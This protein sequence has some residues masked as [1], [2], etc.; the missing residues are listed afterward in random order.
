MNNQEIIDVFERQ[1]KYFSEGG[2]LDVSERKRRLT[3]LR[4]AVEKYSDLIA[5]ALKSD[6]GKSPSESYMCETGLSL[7]EI[8]YQ[9]KHIKKF[10]KRQKV[11]TPMAQWI[12]TSFRY[13]SPYGTVLVMS[14]W[15]YPIL[16]SLDPL[17]EAIAAGNT[18]ILKPSAYSPASSAVLK[19]IIS[20]VLPEEVAAVIEGGREQNKILLDLDFDYIFFTGSKTVGRQVYEKAASRLTPVTLE[21]GGKSPCIV[22]KTANIS[23]AARRIVFGKYL[24]CGQ[25][26]VAPDYVLC[27]GSVKEAFIEEVKK[28]IVT[29]YGKDP[30][31][32]ADYGRIVSRKHFERVAGLIDRNKV[33]FGGQ[34]DEEG[35]RIAPTVMD[36]VT[37]G[38]KV[39]GEEIFG[40]IM[41]IMTFESLEE[42]IKKVNEGESP[43]AAYYFSSDKKSIEKF[44]SELRFG[45]GCINDVLIHLATSYMPFGGFGESGL[46]SYHG[47]TGFDTFTHYKSVIDKKTITD[48]PMRYQPYSKFYDF[49]IRL[50]VR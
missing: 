41:P 43:L 1:K 2:T 20:E 27:H 32:N 13:P 3:A 17:A 4:D 26:C 39:M 45:G 34:T 10:T 35:L 25:T 50:F 29:Q 15:N 48:L 36:G 14:P 12:A 46:G 42:V 37:Y 47:K 24:N 16:L 44:L 8:N 23:L 49:L 28:Q 18:V 21:L 40:P 33:V 22:D 38:D 7:S 31:A 30:L 19:K 5:E 9:I 6:L 11:T